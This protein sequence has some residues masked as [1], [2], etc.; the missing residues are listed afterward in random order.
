MALLEWLDD[1]LPYGMFSLEGAADAARRAKK[2][3]SIY[4]AGQEKAWDG[5]DV[6][7]ELLRKHGGV[8]ID[9]PK[10]EALAQ[11]FSIIMW[12][13]LAAWRIS[14]Q[15]ADRLEPLGAK[16]AATSQAHDEARHF[17]VMHDYL[18]ALGIEVPPMPPWARR[19]VELP[20][21]A[22]EM[23]L[24]V[25]GM[26]LQVETI[27]LTIFQKIR[28]LNVEPVLT[29]LLAYYERDEARHVG[30]GVQ[31]LPTLMRELSHAG[32]VRFIAFQLTMLFC[33]CMGTQELVPDLRVL[34][35]D[36]REFMA[37]GIRR[38]QQVIDEIAAETG[39]PLWGR[40]V[41]IRIFDT[42]AESFFPEGGEDLPLYRR[43]LGAA[44]V[45]SGRRLG[46][47]ARERRA[48][49]RDLV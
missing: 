13:E 18:Q 3:T 7:P 38:Q 34:G 21:R 27:A 24:K 9:S 26:Q 15:L 44:Q 45:L 46:I 16:M 33:T 42:M 23:A 11:L 2:L 8:K 12:G 40:D 35:V 20:L 17:Y 10:R 48:I 31:H 29:D 49:E 6:L 28:E 25:V 5:R 43:A 19:V 39:G 4:H 32:R 30:L 1:P 41:S 47:A 22:K 37:R 36:A 14:A